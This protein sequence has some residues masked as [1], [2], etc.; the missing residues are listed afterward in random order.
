MPKEKSEH[1]RA[2]TTAPSAGGISAAWSRP[3]D[4]RRRTL[5]RLVGDL[6]EADL[7]ASSRRSNPEMRPR[8][9]ELMGIHFDFTALTE[10]DDTVREEILEELR[11][12]NRRRRRPRSRIRRRRR[13]PRRSAQ[14]RAGRN[15]RSS[16]RRRSASRSRAAWT[17]RR[18]PPA[19]ACRP[20]SSRCR[21]PGPS[22]R[23]STT[24]AR[25]PNCRSASTNS[26][27]STRRAAS[28]AR[29]RS[30]GCCAAS[31]RCRSP[32]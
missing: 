10:V 20:S 31:G 1:C 12:A 28:S 6:H 16:C 29:W 27:S 2:T 11:A 30:T 19:G 26:T 18:I 15:S 24:C 3:S 14:G 17:I 13:H 8:L 9:V 22:G 4:R 25:P 5:R 32:N 21:R 23:P 7:G